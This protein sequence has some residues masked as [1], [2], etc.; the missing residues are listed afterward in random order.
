MRAVCLALLLAAQASFVKAEPGADALDWVERIYAA[1]NKL[2]YTGI[3]V[4]QH[5]QLTETSR[6]TRLVDASGAQER[7]EVLDGSPRE[8]IRINNEVQCYLPGSMTVKVEKL[9][10][11]RPLLPILPSQVKDLP[12]NYLIRK[13]E[14]ERIAGFECQAIVLEPRDKMRY[15]HKLWADT[16]TGMLLKAQTL[17]ENNQV[18]EQFMFTQIKVGGNIPRSE[19][20]SKFKGRSK[21]WR[22]EESGGTVTDLAKAGWTIKAAPAGFRKITEMK[23]NIAGTP[24]VGHIVL[25]DG[26]AAVSVFIEPNKSSGKP[27]GLSRQGAIN[28]FTRKLDNHLVTVVGETPAESVKAVAAGIEYR[29]AP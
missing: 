6:I 18:V 13:G 3:F 9:G 20:R 12:E 14:I 1:T 11:N 7:V 21:D 5:G 17:D 26:L 23:R 4:Y 8:I 19:L 2:S 25:S 24:D 22:I 28:I 27:L 15:G 29:R 10:S 16:S